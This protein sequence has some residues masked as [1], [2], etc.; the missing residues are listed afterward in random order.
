MVADV[1][2]AGACSTALRS[3]AIRYVATKAPAEIDPV[4]QLRCQAALNPFVHLKIVLGD[5]QVVGADVSEVLPDTDP[6]DI[7]AI[8]AAKIVRELIL[9]F[10][11][12]T[13]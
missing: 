8:A 4:R 5:L 3:V 13:G 2:F 11:Q 7:T 10:G 6:A 1:N 9:L 12:R